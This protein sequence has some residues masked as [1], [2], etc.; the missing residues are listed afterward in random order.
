MKYTEMVVKEVVRFRSPPTLVPHIVAT[1]FPI[2]EKHT[3]PKGS[4]VFPSVFESSFQG[5]VDAHMFDPDIF[6]HPVKSIRFTNETG[7]HLA[8]VLISVFD[9]DMLLIISCFLLLSFLHW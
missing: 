2:T 5:F 4:L 8:Q 3:I 1:D 6:L 7:F 9:K